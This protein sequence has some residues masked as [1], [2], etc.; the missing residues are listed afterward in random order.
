MLRMNESKIEALSQDYIAIDGMVYKVI[1]WPEASTRDDGY[2][3][4][5]VGW[6]GYERDFVNGMHSR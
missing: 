3:F 6:T 4:L 1:Q 5:Y 2:V